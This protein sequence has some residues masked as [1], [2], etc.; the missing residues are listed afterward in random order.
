MIPSSIL[1]ISAGC[2]AVGVVAQSASPP[3]DITAAYAGLK[4]QTVGIMA[5]ADRP[6]RIDFPTIEADIDRGLQQKIT[7]AADSH[8]DE[9]QHITWTN[10][11]R[12]LEF[13]ENHPEL[14]SEPAEEVAPRLPGGI[15]RLIYVEIV[16]FSLHSNEAVELSRGVLTVNL[17]VVELT[18]GVAKVAYQED[19]LT[20]IYPSD[21]PPEG[22]PNLAD[23]QVYQQ[24]VDALTTELTKRFITHPSDS[25]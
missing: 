11:D 4:G 12:I 22:A 19:D 20:A 15:T 9:V 25:K 17:K 10:S 6:T 7:E 1:A 8:A 14:E 16:S 24:T 13:Q 5:W 2:N 21:A 23:V 18:N 3:P